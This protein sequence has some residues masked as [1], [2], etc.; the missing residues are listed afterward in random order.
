MSLFLWT[1][2]REPLASCPRLF[3]GPGI[4]RYIAF[5][6]P[7]R[8]SPFAPGPPSPAYGALGTTV[9]RRHLRRMVAKFWCGLVRC[10]W[11]AIYSTLHMQ[12]NKHAHVIDVNQFPHRR[13][14]RPGQSQAS[15]LSGLPPKPWDYVERTF[16]GL[17]PVAVADCICYVF[18]AF[19]DLHCIRGYIG[20]GTASFSFFFLGFLCL[21]AGNPKTGN[22]SSWDPK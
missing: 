4:G 14:H 5:L 19:F 3:P 8:R 15:G 13:L 17:P 22:L 10:I 18:R 2:R 20:S 16:W 1:L 11:H 9:C 6:R 12:E 21:P 7:L